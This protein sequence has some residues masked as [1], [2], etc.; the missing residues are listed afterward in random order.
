MHGQGTYTYAK[1]GNKYVSEYRNNK[2]HGQGTFTSANGK[3]VRG[4]FENHNYVG[5]ATIP[6]TSEE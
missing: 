3:V 2:M 5:G 1:S 6:E 4:I